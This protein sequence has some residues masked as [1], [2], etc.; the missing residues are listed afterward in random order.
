MDSF[1]WVA[2]SPTFLRLT[3][4]C[5][6]MPQADSQ[7]NFPLASDDLTAP[8]TLL[9]TGTS[10]RSSWVA[11]LTPKQPSWQSVILTPISSALSPT[12]LGAISSFRD[13]LNAIGQDNLPPT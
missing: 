8:A 4:S 3:L 7:F 12:A 13:T 11:F 9:S 6:A 5:L 1:S 2:V 10:F